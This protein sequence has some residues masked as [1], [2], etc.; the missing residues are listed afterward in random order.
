MAIVEEHFTDHS[1]SYTDIIGAT[2]IDY[3]QASEE[4]MWIVLA[5]DPGNSPVVLVCT[6]KTDRFGSRPV[7]KTELLC[8][9]GVVTWTK[10]APAVVWLG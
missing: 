2:A 6:A 1:T 3:E 4:Y 7:Q 8:L 9:R 5:T 10:H